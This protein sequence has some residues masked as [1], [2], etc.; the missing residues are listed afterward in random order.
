MKKSINELLETVEYGII[1]TNCD[2][3]RNCENC[4][5]FDDGCS[6]ARLKKA[7]SELGV[8]EC[9]EELVN[10]EEVIQTEL[11]YTNLVI[12][13]R[14]EAREIAADYRHRFASAMGASFNDKRFSL[15]WEG[16][17]NA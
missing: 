12:K 9:S 17:K 1:K 7:I 14:D 11:A 3:H 15:P 6:F 5:F 10:A 8:D 16:N 13:E 4:E 2:K